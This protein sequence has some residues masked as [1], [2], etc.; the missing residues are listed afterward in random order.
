MDLV[1]A[2]V[3]RLRASDVFA[4]LVDN[5]YIGTDAPDSADLTTKI[6]QAWLFQGLDND[7]RPYRDPEGSGTGAVV[8]SEREEWTAPNRHNTAYFPQLQMLIYM[9]CTR[10]AAGAPE[11]QDADRKV[12][13]AF[14]LLDRVFHLTGNTEEDQD[15]AGYRVHSS[16]R[17][18]RFVIRDVPQSQSYTVRGEATYETL[19]D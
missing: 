17:G 4:E 16:V 11:E 5:G 19:T 3:R 6:A 10:D 9:D 1:T 13:H 18:S 2:A 7:G 14:R 8:L 12:K 15:W